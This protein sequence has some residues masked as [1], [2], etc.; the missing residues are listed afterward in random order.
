MRKL[1]TVTALVLLGSGCAPDKGGAS[2]ATTGGSTGSSTSGTTTGGTSPTS[3]ALACEDYVVEPADLGTPVEITIRNASSESVWVGALGCG[4]RPNLS[5]LDANQ[6]NHFYASSNCY[7]FA[8]QDFLMLDDCSQSCDDCDPPQ[9]LRLPPGLE[10]TLNW[11]ANRL[12]MV[13]MTAE[14]APGADCQRECALARKA[15]SGPY[16]V[17]LTAFRTCAGADCECDAP[18]GLAC[19][20]SEVELGAP[21]EIMAPLVV[22]DDSAIELV[23]DAP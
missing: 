7:P 22:P 9:A 6:D 11:P 19:P 14:C 5:I 21:V 18:M 17:V 23:I 15:E 13:T 10:L 8:C 1:R 4:T 20:V 16:S 3:G 12:D 2:E